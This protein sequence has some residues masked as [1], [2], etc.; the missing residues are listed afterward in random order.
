[1][2]G[3]GE[4]KVR[5]NNF[6]RFI[7]AVPRWISGAKVPVQSQPKVALDV[8]PSGAVRGLRAATVTLHSVYFYT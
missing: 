8:N 3:K 2:N 4:K 7:G 1:M 6:Q 5:R